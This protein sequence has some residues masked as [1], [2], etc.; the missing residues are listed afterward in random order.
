[1]ARPSLTSHTRA[2][3]EDW[4]ESRI[5]SDSKMGAL[6]SAK[7]RT[8]PRATK[9]SSLWQ[10]FKVLP[11]VTF[12]FVT[13][14]V[15][16]VAYLYLQE[17]HSR[18]DSPFAEPSSPV[19]QVVQTATNDL[20]PEPPEQAAQIINEEP[21]E[22]AP[23]IHASTLSNALENGVKPQPLA[24]ENAL[25][26]AQSSPS[27]T[28]TVTPAAP[29]TT[30]VAKKTAT[31]K[32]KKV[33]AEKKTAADLARAKTLVATTQQASPPVAAAE[34]DLNLLTALVAHNSATPQ[35]ADGAEAL[36]KRCSTLEPERQAQCRVKA[37]S[38][39]RAGEAACKSASSSTAPTS[40]APMPAA[41]PVTKP[42]L[43]ALPE[44]PPINPKVPALPDLSPVQ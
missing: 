28:P 14:M 30:T 38:G 34:K 35:A 41:A 31:D 25:H 18:P 4:G 27:A 22:P 23:A 2:T 44:P 19:S 13:A 21:I 7:A 17:N 11:S 6:T 5:L 24:L 15:G 39:T 40:V 3:E 43:Q 12:F 1:M 32:K 29:A 37:C 42:V 26:Q 20:P 36:L 9:K 8:K 33:A 16:V 10:N